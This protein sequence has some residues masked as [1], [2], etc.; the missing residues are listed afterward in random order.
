MRNLGGALIAALIGAATPTHAQGWQRLPNG[1]LG[2]QTD[3]TYGKYRLR[4]FPRFVRTRGGAYT[5]I[6]S[7][8]AIRYLSRLT[9]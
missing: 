4:G 7:M 6:P 9:G 8:T 5:F 3:Y 2:Y 1:N